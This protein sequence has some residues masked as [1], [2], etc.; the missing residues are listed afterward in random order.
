MGIMI[1]ARHAVPACKPEDLRSNAALGE[2]AGAIGS[3]GTARRACP[4]H[5]H[6]KKHQIL[7]DLAVNSRALRGHRRNR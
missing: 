7:G 6:K 4:W 2:D 1:G 5:L 3:R